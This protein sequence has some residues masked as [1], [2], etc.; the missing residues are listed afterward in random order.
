MWVD[1]IQF[2]EKPMGRT[3]Q[4]G[5]TPVMD[6]TEKYTPALMG[7]ARKTEVLVRPVLHTKT[8]SKE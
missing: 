8:L 7:F 6:S 5:G 4:C 1:W 3:A 2:T